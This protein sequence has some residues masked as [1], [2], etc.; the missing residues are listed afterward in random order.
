MQSNTRWEKEWERAS[1]T[2]NIYTCVVI[3]FLLY[4]CNACNAPDTGPDTAAYRYRISIWTGTNDGSCF[5]FSHDWWQWLPFGPL[6]KS[7]IHLCENYDYI[8]IVTAYYKPTYRTNHTI[9]IPIGFYYASQPAACVVCV[10]E[11]VR[12][13]VCGLR[14]NSLLGLAHALSAVFFFSV[15]ALFTQ[16]N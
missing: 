15:L 10:R 14:A 9:S 12:V 2:H 1:V 16:L 11:C 5:G 6:N 8:S 13:C 7:S 3:S 4:F